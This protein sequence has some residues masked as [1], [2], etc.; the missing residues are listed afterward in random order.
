MLKGRGGGERGYPGE[1]GRGTYRAGVALLLVDAVLREDDDTPGAARGDALEVAEELRTPLDAEHLGAARDLPAALK[2]HLLVGAREDHDGLVP[3]AGVA[4]EDA[5][6]E[7]LDKA[8]HRRVPIEH[9][10]VAGLQDYVWLLCL[11]S[12]PGSPPPRSLRAGPP[13]QSI[14]RKVRREGKGRGGG[15]RGA[16]GRKEGREREG[17]GREGKGRG[18]EGREGKGRGRGGKGREG[19]GREGKGREGKGKGKGKGKGREGKGREG[20]GREGEG[21]EGKEGKGRE[22][23]GRGGEGRGGE[24]EGEGRGRGREGEGKGR[25]RRKGRGGDQGRGVG[26][27]NENENG[28]ERG[29]GR[30]R[31]RG[32]EEERGGRERRREEHQLSQSAP[33]RHPPFSLPHP[34]PPPFSPGSC[35]SG[36]GK[37]SPDAPIPTR[38]ETRRSPMMVRESAI[39][40]ATG[41]PCTPA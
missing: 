33:A 13:P 23:K 1:G 3:H 18:R 11:P 17:K 37:G 31:T 29:R 32:R 40:R 8:R 36:G 25:G 35:K 12:P 30:R 19:K 9:H 16:G 7:L 22:G 28:K 2:H 38:M 6:A 14:P 15:G 20:K 5:V 24:G 10:E 21:R 39:A 34:P 41:P 27:G 4:V 26:K